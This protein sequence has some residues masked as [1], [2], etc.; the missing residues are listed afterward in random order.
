MSELLSPTAIL[1]STLAILLGVMLVLWAI[2]LS[3]GLRWSGATNRNWGRIAVA[4][5]LAN[6]IAPWPALYLSASELTQN[7]LLN[8][9]ISLVVHVAMI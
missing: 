3:W 1:F 6:L 8:E 7:P 5:I 2:G 9:A 4:T